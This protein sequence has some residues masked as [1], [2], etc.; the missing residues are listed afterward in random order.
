VSPASHPTP[1]DFEAVEDDLDGPTS[2]VR[3]VVPV[4]AVPSMAMGVDRLRSLPLDARAGYLL[5][6]VDGRCSVETILDLCAE[7]LKTD[8]AM[9]ILARLLQLGAIR[10]RD[11]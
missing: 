8:E 4:F 11:P 7:D 2:E 6:L 5:S 10:L 3:P 1:P 9:G